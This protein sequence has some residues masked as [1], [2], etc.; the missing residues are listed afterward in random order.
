MSSPGG[1]GNGFSWI[2][3]TRTEFH[4]LLRWL[5]IHLSQGRET[6]LVP[7]NEKD[8]EKGPIN[9]RGYFTSSNEVDKSVGIQPKHVGVT[10]EDLQVVVPGGKDHK[11]K[12]FS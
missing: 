3:T 9:L 7:S 6:E 5:T 12:S 11:V 2:Q 4:V 10:W 8:V 1:D